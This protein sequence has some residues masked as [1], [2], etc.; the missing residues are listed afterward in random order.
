MT[1]HDDTRDLLLL[2]NLRISG[3][4][5]RAAGRWERLLHHYPGG[6]R[7]QAWLP[8]NATA[9]ASYDRLL[10]DGSI[11]LDGEANAAFVA[12]PESQH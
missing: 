2:A 1:T 4:L 8:V 3:N 5:R 7:T 9:A 12:W 10:R 6:R 11:S